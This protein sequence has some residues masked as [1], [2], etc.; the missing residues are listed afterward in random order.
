MDAFRFPDG[1]RLG[2]ATAA[3]QIDGGCQNGNWYD[4]YRQGK[5]KDNSSPDVATRHPEHLEEDTAMLVF[6]GIR[7]Y[8]MGLEWAKLEPEDGV[9]SDEAFAQVRKELLYLRQQG[10]R[11]LLTIH[12]FSNPMWFERMGGFLNKNSVRIFL[13]FTDEVVRRLGDL[14]DEYITVNE[15]NV[16]ASGC[17][18]FGDWPPAH[19]NFFEMWRVITRLGE[20]HRKAYLHIHRIRREMGLTGTKV[21][22]AH[23]MRVFTPVDPKNPW[24]RFCARLEKRLYQDYITRTYTLGTR[25]YHG[26]YA[27]FHGINYYS[28]TAVSGFGND[29]FTGVPKNDLGWEIYPEGLIACVREQLAVINLP[30][31]VTEN[32]T[33]DT[34]D[35]FRARFL[36]DQLKSIS[37]SGLPIERYY[38]WCFVDNWEWVEGYTA[39]FGLVALDTETLERTVKNSGFFYRDMIESG[40]VTDA[41]VE[42]YVKGQVYHN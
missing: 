29:A 14:V 17:Y 27:D 25:R 33:A 40:G 41:A 15:P 8:R 3:T 36:Y 20:C 26:V 11:P 38:H 12:H 2:V 23:H 24:H 7:D 31:Y 22:F 18:F 42:Q 5:I 28:R 37:E 10:V 39:K 21:G 30:V 6:L 35:A 13:R 34:E 19:H 16:Y 9:F 1:L 4:W 32:G